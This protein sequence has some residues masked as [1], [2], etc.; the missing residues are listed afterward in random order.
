[1]KIKATIKYKDRMRY[2]LKNGKAYVKF[3]GAKRQKARLLRTVYQEE[4]LRELI[5]RDIDSFRNTIVCNCDYN[6]EGKFKDKLEWFICFL[7]NDFAFNDDIGDAIEGNRIC[8]VPPTILNPESE[9][10]EETD[11][12]DDEKSDEDDEETLPF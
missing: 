2:Y 3:V 10:G 4:G 11:D 6:K 1:M 7:S 5:D 12:T 9:T 8:K